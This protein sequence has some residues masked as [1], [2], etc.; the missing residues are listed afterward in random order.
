MITKSGKDVSLEAL[1]PGEYIVPKGEERF[2]HCLIEV[3]QFS[4]TTGVKQSKPRLQ[5][6]GLKAF[7]KGVR[8]NLVKQ[9]YT[10]TVLHDPSE[11]IK[12]HAEQVA[13]R[14]QADKAAKEA[15]IQA[16]VD[17]AVA[18]AIEAYKAAEKA[19]KAPKKSTKTKAEDSAQ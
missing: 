19:A 11:W 17:A 18:K 13:Q 4:R 6:F 2:Y 16:K 9:G 1:T 10:I 7:R 3:K 5:K 14:A 8:E 15:E 12:A